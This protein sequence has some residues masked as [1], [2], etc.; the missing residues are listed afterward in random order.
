MVLQPRNPTKVQNIARSKRR[1]YRRHT[2][3]KSFPSVGRKNDNNP[4]GGWASLPSL[5]PH[6][7]PLLP[8][9]PRPPI[10]SITRTQIFDIMWAEAFWEGLLQDFLATQDPRTIMDAY[11]L[12][13][14]SSSTNDGVITVPINRTFISSLEDPQCLSSR[15]VQTG[16]II[17]SGASVCI[18]PHRS[19][20]ITYKFTRIVK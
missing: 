8:C 15:S 14:A 3:F 9:L 4:N 17:D 20:F 18:S 2:K 11:Q 19:D 1:S 16:V 10:V 5:L 7:V 12:F 13:L 6:I